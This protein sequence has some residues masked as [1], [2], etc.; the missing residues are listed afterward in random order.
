MTNNKTRSIFPEERSGSSSR[1]RSKTVSFQS[2]YEKSNEV[3]KLNILTETTNKNINSIDNINADCI[4]DDFKKIYHI[5]QSSPPPSSKSESHQQQQNNFQIW[6]RGNKRFHTISYLDTAESR[7]NSSNLHEKMELD[8]IP[9]INNKENIEDTYTESQ[10]EDEES[11]NNSVPS[12]KVSQIID[13]HNIMTDSKSDHL[14]NETHL[15]KAIS[16]ID[17]QQTQNIL[18]KHNNPVILVHRP[19]KELINKTYLDIFNAD[20][21]KIHYKAGLSKNTVASLPSLHPEIKRNRK[22]K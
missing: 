12:I 9:I 2:D 16:S 20:A 11:S 10:S 13:N 21:N 15:I 5:E 17:K 19:L 18:V 6:R 22:T 1:R 14:S 4:H 3:F 7:Y 8:P